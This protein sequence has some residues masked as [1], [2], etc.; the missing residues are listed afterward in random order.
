M[1]Y[2]ETLK[3]PESSIP[4]R[5]MFSNKNGPAAR[6]RVEII[7]KIISEYAFSKIVFDGYSIAD[8][9]TF[10]PRRK[11][12]SSSAENAFHSISEEDA[13]GLYM[14]DII[15]EKV[16]SDDP[17]ISGIVSVQRHE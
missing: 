14:I 13:D 3:G 11:A 8:R 2:T 9:E 5:E 16:T 15:R 6:I 17:R 10:F 4:K 12:R 1:G 7:L